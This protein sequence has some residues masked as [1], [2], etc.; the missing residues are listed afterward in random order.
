VLLGRLIQ[1]DVG[2][3]GTISRI[4]DVDDAAWPASRRQV[5]NHFPFQSQSRRNMAMGSSRAAR[6]AGIPHANAA[7]I[8]INSAVPA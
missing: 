1:A 4:R 5:A 3:T 7:T 8:N 6:K 2:Q